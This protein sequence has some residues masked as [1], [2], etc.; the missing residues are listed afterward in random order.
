[1]SLIKRFENNW[2]KKFIFL[3]P[4]N[5]KIIAAV[6]GGIDS[7]VLTDIL[8]QLTFDFT[9]A[10]CNFQLRGDESIRDEK[11]VRSLS[12][13][14]DCPI[15]VIKFDT[16]QYAEENKIGIQEAA[17]ILRYQWFQ[18]LMEKEKKYST[19]N[20]LLATA[21]HADDNI[22]TL[23]I[24]FFRGTG[25]QGLTGITEFDKKNKIIRPLLFARRNE[26]AEYARQ[27]NLTWVE[28]SSNESDKYTRNFIR[29]QIIPLAKKLFDNA[30]DNLL[31][32][33]EK[34]K[35]AETLYLQALEDHKKKLIVISSEPKANE[36]SAQVL[37][38]AQH[39]NEQISHS[40]RNDEI[41]IPILLL[42]KS[43]PLQTIIWEIIKPYSFSSA[44]VDEVI[45][46]LDAG[47]GSYIQSS[48]HRIIK[49]RKHII[50][51]S[52]QQQN[53]SLILI[54]KENRLIEFD[55]QKIKLS[56]V[57]NKNISINTSETIAQLDFLE[58]EYPLI[59]RKWKQGDYFYPLGMRKKK[60]VSKFLI[61][62]KLSLTEKENVWVVESNKKIV[63]LVGMRIDDRFKI[64]PA[65]K[66]I[67]KMELV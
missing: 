20:I 16:N 11:F 62:A 60:K 39:D 5:C 21:H 37:R 55:A 47:N 44:Q 12:K 57:E 34:L 54:E 52:V 35:E 58:I 1:M 56:I 61:D 50:I 66:Q 3:T 31:N 19:K 64:I 67:L 41:Q 15:A 28:D 45:K 43:V 7:A 65:T 33:I 27:N 25:L 40:V 32:N 46:L 26:I 8:H 6:S 49:N 4:A 48:S 9:I 17:R 30:D 14:Y 63:W 23:L 51:T 10:H 2:D 53:S 22:E 13:K 38:Q 59:L 42:K 18:E 36:K 29:H 24:N